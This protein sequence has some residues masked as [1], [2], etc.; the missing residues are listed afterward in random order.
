[1][2]DCDIEY[3]AFLSSCGGQVQIPADYG[4]NRATI[5]LNKKCNI[6]DNTLAILNNWW[7][8]ATK[9]DLS[10]GAVYKDQTQ[11]EFGV[12]VNGATKGFACSY[13]NC[14]G[15]NGEL[16]CLYS[17]KPA[18]GGN[19]YTKAAGAVCNACPAG[20]D[21]CIGSLCT[22]KVY[23]PEP[24]IPDPKAEPQPACT[25]SNP[26]DD[27]MTHDMQMTAR[28]MANYYRNLVATGWA[29]D[30]K[31]YAPTAKAMNALEYE[32]ND[33]GKDAKTEAAKCT[34]AS[35]TPTPGYVL[36]S[37]KV[38]NLDLPRAEVLKELSK[39][40]LTRV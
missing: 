20:T 34:A 16:L 12:M 13:S 21:P 30:K 4:V 5:K 14:G 26:S 39:K 27:G 23:E 35:Y 22:P 2:W 33:A 37:Y 1:N 24:G 10:A 17:A 6:N 11:K 38:R 25:T 29:E 32:C 7:S 3:N 31:G 19:L 15:S 36:S 28:D 18:G 8:Q 9:E 40:S